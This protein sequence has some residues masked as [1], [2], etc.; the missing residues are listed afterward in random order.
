QGSFDHWRDADKQFAF[1]AAC[2][3]LSRARKNPE[4]FETHLPIG[5]DGTCNGIQH[6]AML[7]RDE[8]AAELVNLIDTGAPQDIYLAVT[9]HVMKLLDGED[10]RLRTKGNEAQDAWCFG[11][12]RER[13]RPLTDKDRRKLFKGPVMTFPYSATPAGMADE[14]VETYR[15]LFDDNGPWPTA[16]FLAKAVGLACEDKLSGPVRIMKYVR[17]LAR[18]RYKQGKFLEWRSPTGFP[19]ANRYQY[20]N[21]VPLDLCFGIRSRYKVAD[22]A[23]P[24]MRKAKILNAASPNFIHSLDAAHL[25]RTVLAA[26]SE[27]IRDI[28]PVHDS[29]SCLAPFARLFGQVI[30]REL[31]ML[32]IVGDPLA[33]LRNANVDD[34]KNPKLLPLPERG[35]LNPDD[36]PKGEYSFM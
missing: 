15:D 2:M 5:F 8:E 21:I 36:V 14:I 28:L 33:A 31:A 30:R 34:P 29:Y 22:G 13:L 11:W 26:N 12:W 18:Y 6:L 3:E 23:L 9:W 1:V 20:S 25:I 27:G 7:S 17:E 16:R 35:N 19:V 4:G 24:E 32:Y 10:H